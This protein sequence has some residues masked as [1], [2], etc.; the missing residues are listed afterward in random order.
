MEC[1]RL[2]EIDVRIRHLSIFRRGN[3]LTDETHV[4]GRKLSTSILMERPTTF[5][6][7][8]VMD[9]SKV[10]ASQLTMNF[11]LAIQQVLLV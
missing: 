3:F 1:L 8:V 4:I 10:D 7:P 2:Y 11:S 9:R 5:M 6:L